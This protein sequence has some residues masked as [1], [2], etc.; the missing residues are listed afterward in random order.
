[1]VRRSDDIEGSMRRYRMLVLWFNKCFLKSCLS[2]RSLKAVIV[3]S[4]RHA[5]GVEVPQQL[6][7]AHRTNGCAQ[8]S[9]TSGERRSIEDIPRSV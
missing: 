1:M 5:M 2:A 4:T 6:P 7:D 3:G 9:V 8:L